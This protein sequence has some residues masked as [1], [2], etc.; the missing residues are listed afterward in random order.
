M[1][2]KHWQVGLFPLSGVLELS[3]CLHLNMSGLALSRSASATKRPW[4]E[5]STVTKQ[6]L[7]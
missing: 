4:E 7:Q 1:L 5:G 6:A 2:L 3:S